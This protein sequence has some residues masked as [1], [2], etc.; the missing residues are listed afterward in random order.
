MRWRA[1][2]GCPQ[3]EAVYEQLRSLVPDAAL[4]GGELTAE[5]TITRVGRRFR[6]KLTV[7][8]DETQGERTIDADSCRDL[9][10][11]AAVALG[12]LVQSADPQ[13]GTEVRSSSETSAAGSDRTERASRGAANA[14][15]PE[16]ARRKQSRSASPESE[17]SEGREPAAASQRFRPH[18]RAFLLLGPQAALELGP[19][20][21]PTLGVSF[22]A[23]FDLAHWR[24]LANLQLFLPQTLEPPEPSVAVDVQRVAAEAW[25]C[26]RWGSGALELAPCLGAGIERLTA[27]G[28]GARV[29]SR[30]SSATWLSVGAGAIGRWFVTDWFALTLAIGA[31]YE[32]ARPRV[33]ID[34]L[35]EIHQVA[36][37]AIGLRAGPEWIL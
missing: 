4:Q 5:G 26:R 32:T 18:E 27:S 19:L 30:T 13:S 23:G 11:A 29:A 31:K 15:A 8:F 9:A 36:P 25:A 6:L 7:R 24:F 33:E 28:T 10:G 21:D 3:R 37:A 12:L 20:P 2:A 35:G 16:R 1:P 14:V 34:G 17:A 22:G